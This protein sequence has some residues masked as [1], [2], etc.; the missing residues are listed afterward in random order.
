M[1][2]RRRLTAAI[3]CLG[4]AAL[5]CHDFASAEPQYAPIATALVAAAPVTVASVAV[6]P[7]APP[8][9]EPVQVEQT[10]EPAPDP[11]M[12][13]LAPEFQPE[14]PTAEHSPSPQFTSPPPVEEILEKIEP[15]LRQ[16]LHDTLEKIAW[17]S[18]GDLTEA[19]VR[20]S[21][22]RVESIAWEVIP[23]MAETLI[24]EEIRRIKAQS[25]DA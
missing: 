3:S 15:Q 9:A 1:K 24:Q 20:Q 10:A 4:L 18:F 8:T 19:I 6:P 5:S 25:E 16:Q 2:I 13:V 12:S 7:P 17:E 22:E 11:A 23:R 21:V 14:I